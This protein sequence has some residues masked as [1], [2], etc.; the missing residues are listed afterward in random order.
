M[1]PSEK[2]LAG[3]RIKARLAAICVVL[4]GAGAW[5]RP[6]QPSALAAMQER[7]APL[8]EER[9]EQRDAARPRGVEDFAPQLNARGV[10]ITTA[11]DPSPPVIDDF[12]GAPARDVS[13]AVAVAGEYLLTHEAA[14]DGAADATVMVAPNRSAAASVVGFDPPSGLVL[15]RAKADMTA[16]IIATVTPAPGAIAAAAASIGGR[17]VLVPVFITSV[18]AARYDVSAGA[19]LAPGMPIF[20]VA[21][22]L[23]AIAAQSGSAAVV[24]DALPRLLAMANGE[25]QASSIGIA[26]Q[27]IDDRLRAA[28]GDTGVVVVTVVAGGPADRAGIDEGD[29]LVSAGASELTGAGASRILS[30]LPPGTA[31]DITVRRQQRVQTVSVTPE[32]A[33]TVRAL[34]RHRPTAA[35]PEAR[36]L[37]AAPVLESAGVAATATVISINGRPVTAVPQA[38]RDLARARGE[39]VVLLE[40]GGRRFFAIL[41]AKQ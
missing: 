26:Y 5:L 41:P 10:V 19:R 18:G 21:G 2:I 12:G 39:V 32:A 3:F 13:F 25:Q 8:L 9:V 35:G 36:E 16:A 4:L 11:D 1:A 20:N 30:A 34:A 28:F 27:A 6:P 24:R 37:F 22:D 7:P 40:S 33:Y 14:L 17:E 23:L 15:L 31:V 29:V 38:V